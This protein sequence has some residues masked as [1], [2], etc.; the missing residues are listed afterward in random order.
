MFIA[1]YLAKRVI[2]D[3]RL[4]RHKIV[5]D[6]VSCKYVKYLSAGDFRLFVSHG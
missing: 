6:I 5:V 4:G 1:T 3:L 2:R